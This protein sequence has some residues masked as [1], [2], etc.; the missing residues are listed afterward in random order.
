MRLIPIYISQPP[1]PP[2]NPHRSN[3][4]LLAAVGFILTLTLCG[5]SAQAVEFHVFGEVLHQQQA[6]IDQWLVLHPEVNWTYVAG[7][8]TREGEL[9]LASGYN[10]FDVYQAGSWV[11]GG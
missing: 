7:Q 6:M 8:G 10:Y 3:L 1:P 4:P 11:V 5:T 2:P 9:D